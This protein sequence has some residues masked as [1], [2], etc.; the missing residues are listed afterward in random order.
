MKTI[1]KNS[2]FILFFTVLIFGCSKDSS[3]PSSDQA[4]TSGGITGTGGSLARFSITNGHLYILTQNT[5]FTY[6]L[7]DPAHPLYKTSINVGNGAE[8]IMTLDNNLL[9]GTQDG[10]LIYS[11]SDASKPKYISTY[12]HVRSCDPVV[13]RGSY[14]YSTLRTSGNCTRGVNRLDVINIQNINSPEQTK[15]I[16]MENPIGLGL[17]E[18]HLYVCD[19]N[20]IKVYAIANPASP[21]LIAS[22]PLGGC[23][24][25]IINNDLLIAVTTNGVTQFTINKSGSLTQLSTI[26]TY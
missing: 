13:A 21:E 20:K 26:N 8:T 25:I 2:I 15:S 16:E 7:E 6:S 17:S 1:T 5:L 4:S 10:V 3:S 11:L 22:I 24:D 18:N 14:A 12:A 19:N 23:F 9:L